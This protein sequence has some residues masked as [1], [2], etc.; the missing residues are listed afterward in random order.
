VPTTT[1]VVAIAP[2]ATSD[3]PPVTT[4]APIERTAAVIPSHLDADGLLLQ[5]PVASDGAG[6]S[7]EST[8]LRVVCDIAGTSRIHIVSTYMHACGAKQPGFIIVDVKC[9]GGEQK[10][11]ST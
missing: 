5:L 9:F 2:S 6:N 3:A 4:A 1:R 8:A 10:H 11:S 7:N